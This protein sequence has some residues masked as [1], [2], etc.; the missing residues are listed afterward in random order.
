MSSKYV[1]SRDLLDCKKR[2]SQHITKKGLFSQRTLSQIIFTLYNQARD[3]EKTDAL[4][5]HISEQI[6][7]FNLNNKHQSELS[8]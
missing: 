2:L 4:V 6:N 1:R 7:S 5:E 3:I 8:V